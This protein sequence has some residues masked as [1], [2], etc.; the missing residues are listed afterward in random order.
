[1]GILR[2]SRVLVAGAWAAVQLLPV[3][4]GAQAI[5]DDIAHD[6]TEADTPL[7]AVG[8]GINIG[9]PLGEF[10][11]RAGTGWG[12]GGHLLIEFD[13]LFGIEPATWPPLRIDGSWL[14]YAHET[15]DFVLGSVTE[16]LAIRSF[17]IGPQ[18]GSTRGP[19]RFDAFAI[20]GLSL[21]GTSTTTNVLGQSDSDF[22]TSSTELF[23]AIGAGLSTDLRESLA[24]NLSASLRYHGSASYSTRPD[25]PPAPGPANLA[26]FRAGLSWKP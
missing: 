26:A 23:L 11:D 20:A 12:V 3:S 6:S 13:E 21:F 15:D 2:T 4:A 22:D 5:G 7:V 25:E 16:S 10:A 1:M 19:T 8:L 9:V 14:E 17:G 18:L 24:L